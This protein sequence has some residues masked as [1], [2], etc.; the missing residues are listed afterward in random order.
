MTAK[1]PKPKVSVVSISYNQEAYI[2]KALQSFV[3][4]KTTFPIEV[5]I[6]DDCS[7]DGTAKIIQK[8][9]DNFP[10]IVKPILRK[11][12]VGAIPNLKDALQHATGKYIALCEGDDY[13]T[14]TSKLQKQADLLDKNRQLGLCFHPVRVFF[15]NHEQPDSVFPEKDFVDGYTVA[16]LLQRNFIQTNSVMYRK[17]NYDKLPK[18]I[19]PGDWYLHLYHAQFGKIGFIDEVMSAYRRH[20]GGL[21]WDSY[22]NSDRIWINNGIKH[23]KLFLEVQDLYG[24]NKVYNAIVTQQI[25]KMLLGLFRIDQK[26]STQL[27]DKALKLSGQTE[28]QFAY[29]LD[30]VIV[31]T[32]NQL[33]AE[34]TKHQD[35]QEEL[36]RLENL[37]EQRKQEI[38]NMKSSK[39][40]RLQQSYLKLRS[41]F[42][43][44][45]KN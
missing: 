29:Y 36:L 10:D 13:W 38:A 1:Y 8:Y 32:N 41:L 45:P 16:N 7:T 9:A 27:F 30:S 20:P 43:L 42:G 11:K 17:Q 19:L 22:N 31:D 35:N 5:I 21:W 12:N 40:W 3:D 24:K 14:D 26:H 6:A 33:A 15:E 28:R 37:L 2:E 25:N 39:A 23:L 34:K 18:D 44:S 4:Q